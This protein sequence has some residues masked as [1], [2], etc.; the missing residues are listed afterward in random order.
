MGNW[1]F[2]CDICQEVCPWN[3]DA[4][5]AAAVEPDL[6]PALGELI[7]LDDDGFRRRYGRTA[8]RRTKRRGLLRNAAIALGNSGN[9]A[10]VPILA[11]VLA[12]EPEA[13]VRAHAAWALG[14]LATYGRPHSTRPG[15]PARPGFRRPR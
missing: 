5:R 14:R 4:T 3:G 10:A 1:I 2:G 6:M 9:P 11:A 8:I 7:A 15:S 13:L 12:N